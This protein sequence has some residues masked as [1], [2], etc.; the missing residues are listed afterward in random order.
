MVKNENKNQLEV[1]EEKLKELGIL[2]VL[3]VVISEDEETKYN[4]VC[5]D[6]T[7]KTVSASELI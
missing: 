4:C 1:S 6:G 5:E 2:R 7:I 3:N